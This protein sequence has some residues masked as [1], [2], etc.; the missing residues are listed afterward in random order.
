PSRGLRRIELVTRQG[1]YALPFEVIW[2]DDLVRGVLSTDR[3]RREADSGE[4]SAYVGS[5]SP[6]IRRSCGPFRLPHARKGPRTV[7]LDASAHIWGR[8]EPQARPRYSQGGRGGRRA[9]AP[10]EGHP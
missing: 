7:Y 1:G 3:G 4:K 8:R 5:S 2:R 6:W 10:P 9:P